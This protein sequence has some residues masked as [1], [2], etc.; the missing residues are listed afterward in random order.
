LRDCGVSVR[1]TPEF[2]EAARPIHSPGLEQPLDLGQAE[3]HRPALAA[4][5]AE[6]GKVTGLEAVEDGV[7]GE[8][9][10]LGELAG[11]EEALAHAV[12]SA[13]M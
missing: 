8:A 3:T 13:A 2:H 10:Q 6:A 4:E 1:P 11:G 12:A 7:G 5:E 9:E